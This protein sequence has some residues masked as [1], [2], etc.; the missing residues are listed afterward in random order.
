[1]TN[2]LLKLIE[3]YPENPWDSENISQNPNITIEFIKNHKNILN[4]FYLCTNLSLQDMDELITSQIFIELD[5]KQDWVWKALS[6]N[7]N[8]SLGFIRENLDKYFNWTGLSYNP[9]LTWNFIEQN[10]N[11][12]WH[13]TELTQHKCVTW[14]IIQNHSSCPWD[15]NLLSLNPNITWE[16][17][18]QIIEKY[19]EKILNKNW[20]L[21]N[22]CRNPN[23]TIEI[24]RNNPLIRW[25]FYHLSNNPMLTWEII[26]QNPDIPWDWNSLTSHPCITWE[27]IQ[28]NR[29]KNWNII[30]F[31]KNPNLTWEIVHDNQDINWDWYEILCNQFDKH[32]YFQKVE[33]CYL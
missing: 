29:N 27:I 32:E 22:F 17:A 26:Q 5:W 16:M 21:E 33:T 18:N 31:S 23:M 28:Q 9:N 14:D 10:I 2:H 15:W 8:L 24:I 7:K 13:W 25:E 3:L 1:M 11:M 4:D 30:N 19:P 20:F 12:P 6:Y